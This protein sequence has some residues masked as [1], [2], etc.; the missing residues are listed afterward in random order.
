MSQSKTIKKR[1]LQ[2]IYW[3]FILTTAYFIA[4]TASL[5]AL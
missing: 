2:I 5:S 1:N 4:Y 3:S